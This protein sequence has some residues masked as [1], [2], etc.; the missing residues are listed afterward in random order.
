MIGT[1]VLRN[2]TRIVGLVEGRLLETYG[3]RLEASN[4]SLAERERGHHGRI[5][6]AGEEATHR[7]VGDEA[8]RHRPIE[9]R[10]KFFAP[11]LLGIGWRLLEG[12]RLILPVARNAHRVI[13][14]LKA[15][16]VAGRQFLHAVEKCE[17]R[18]HIPVSEIFLKRAPRQRGG[19]SRVL[20]E[21]GQFG[22]EYKR[23]I[24][25]I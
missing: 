16:I 7:D 21:C 1:D 15:E 13:A 5:D 11:A 9:S 3:E 14:K 8:T 23:V 22:G 10:G 25:V 18:R 2:Q 12:F 6:A 17:R 24:T 19:N 4:T 20:T